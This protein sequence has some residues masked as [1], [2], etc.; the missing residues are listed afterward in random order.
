VLDRPSLFKEDRW[1][2]EADCKQAGTLNVGES[3]V[4]ISKN[5]TAT[6]SMR[7]NLSQV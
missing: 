1:H 4:I 7:R 5:T 2:R 6:K 3:R